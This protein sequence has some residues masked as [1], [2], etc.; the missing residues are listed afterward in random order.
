M[1][2]PCCGETLM[3][4]FCEISLCDD[5]ECPE[6]DYVNDTWKYRNAD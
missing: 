2:C 4:P 5:G 6:C 3:C 1:E